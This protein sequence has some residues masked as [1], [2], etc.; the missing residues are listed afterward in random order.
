[1]RSVIILLILNCLLASC[2]TTSSK[3]GH[4][5][6]YQDK[7]SKLLGY[8]ASDVEQSG[9]RPGVIIVHEWWGHNE[10]VRKRAEMLA[11][12]GYVALAIDMYGDGKQA[13][14]P[15]DAGKFASQVFK[16]LPKAKE[17]FSAGL[18]ILK[19]HPHVDKTKIAAIGYC[20]GGGVVLT[21]ARM[22]LNLDGFVSF[23]GSLQSPV[24]SR[25]GSVK[26]KVLVFNGAK[27][28]MVK[29]DHIKSF[30]K[31]MKSSRV[32]YRF[33]N[34][35]NAVHAFTNKKATALGEKFKLPLAYDEQADSDSWAQTLAFFK[36][37]F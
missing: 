13:G 10:Y 11:K 19:N 14:H 23:H 6:G 28:P 21:M 7:D 4:E 34:Y 5:I 9:K 1:V 16:N 2:S 29:E 32:D 26:G 37:I 15:K 35:P 24:K 36:E 18:E 27:D 30:K 17:R 22:G 31:E 12:A 20:F 8:L 25:K 33:V 3:V